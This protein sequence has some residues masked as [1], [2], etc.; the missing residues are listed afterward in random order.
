[1]YVAPKTWSA[2]AALACLLVS[3]TAAQAVT[4][5]IGSATGA[6]GST[7]MIQATLSTMG[8]QVGGVSNNI[9]FDPATPIVD[10]QLNPALNLSAW[11][12]QPQGCTAGVDCQQARF[13]NLRFS[14]QSI[15]DGTVLYTCT[16]HIA[17]NAPAQAFPL[18][19]SSPSGSTLDPPSPL[20]VDCPNAQVEVVLPTP[21]PTPTSTATNTPTRTP[22][23]TRTST[24]T[25]GGPTA[26]PTS[27]GTPAPGGGGGGG[28]QIASPGGRDARW[29]LWVAAVVPL[30]LWGHRRLRR[31]P[32]Q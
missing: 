2:M 24:V 25:P 10:C 30:W 9:V 31:N 23:A 4:I 32:L 3:T 21:T 28:C 12:L 8:V 20:T 6:P 16:I 27:T 18:V 17:A 14:S 11:E 26:T 29:P 1:M 13:L 15:P 22:T 5:N 7:I 19:C